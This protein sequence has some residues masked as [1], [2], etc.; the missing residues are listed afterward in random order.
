MSR[1][2]RYVLA[3]KCCG[4]RFLPRWHQTWELVAYID[5]DYA[6]D[7]KQE[8]VSMDTWCIFVVYPLHGEV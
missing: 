1:I 3:T 5:S 2:I 8:E 4:L 7:K 6:S